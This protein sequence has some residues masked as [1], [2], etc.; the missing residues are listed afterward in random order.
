MNNVYKHVASGFCAGILIT[1]V[2][3]CGVL[4]KSKKTVAK[5]PP[6]KG[7]SQ[8]GSLA[9]ESSLLG[10]ADLTLSSGYRFNE[11][12]QSSLIASMNK[13]GRLYNNQPQP[14]AAPTT[15][16]VFA[17]CLTFG[18][19]TV[20][21][22]KTSLKLYKSIDV[23]DCFKNSESNPVVRPVFFKATWKYYIYLTCTSK[24]LSS[25]NGKKISDLAADPKNAD[26]FGCTNG[27]RLEQ[28]L[29]ESDTTEVTAD[30]TRVAH[31]RALSHTG[32]VDFQAC[33][34][35][36]SGTTAKQGDDCIDF[37]KSEF[38]AKDTS[39]VNGSAVSETKTA[40]ISQYTYNGVTDDHSADTNVWHNTGKIGVSY[41]GWTGNVTYSGSNTAPSYSFKKTSTS[42][43][44]T[45]ALTATASE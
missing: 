15:P 4:P 2:V 1:L 30:G 28:T 14:P 21:S 6:A 39:S 27:T 12:T 41:N 42:A 38:D 22:T 3:G 26:S 20:E 7:Q 11:V 8:D 17:R 36:S 40:D 16:D 45:G 23:S 31:L 19:I 18:D 35:S 32:T 29:F 24:D 34:F 10:A 37:S 5:D 13:D 43:P 25:L 9:H 44:T 33:G